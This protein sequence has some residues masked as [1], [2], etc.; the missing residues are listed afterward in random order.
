[1]RFVDRAGE[2]N[3]LQQRLG[4]RSSLSL[5]YGQRRVGKTFL[6]QHLVKDDTQAVYF[7]ADEGSVG[8]QLRRFL[9]AARL[10]AAPSEWGTALTLL[11][12]GAI[13]D[14]R[15]LVLVLDE[16]Q[17]LIAADPALPSILA[18][19]WDEYRHRGELHVILC[20]SALGT[21]ARLGDSGQP[22]H[23]RFDLKLKLSPFGHR[24]AALFVPGWSPVD[25]LRCYGVFGGIARHLV[26]VNPDRSLGEN[27]VASIMDPLG[28]LHEAPLDMLRVEHLSA[29]ADAHAV[30]SAVADGENRFGAIAARCGLSAARLNY[31][32]KE[33]TWLE[34]L[35]RQV[36]FGD[37][38]R[39]KFARYR[40][41]DPL[42]SFWFRWVM[43]NR[44]AIFSS[45]PPRVWEERVAPRIPNHMGRVFEEIVTAAVREGALG[46]GPIDLVAPW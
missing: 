18:R 39:A 7:L 35:E 14:E 5:V 32:L 37:G 42:V 38:P 10:D 4:R 6:L 41:T 11:V 16:V 9:A 28:S 15:R 8:G 46:L 20:G 40:C 45:T 24:E 34:I 12:Q 31:V 17:H 2:L 1:M 30:L 44:S 22:L 33:L 26:E 43:P 27:A 13:L 3:A 25:A 29:P 19:L 21:M 23:G 36:R